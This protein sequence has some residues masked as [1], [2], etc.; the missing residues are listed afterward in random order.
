MV[1]IF[2]KGEIEMNL[3]VIFKRLGRSEFIENNIKRKIDFALERFRED[4]DLNAQVKVE[5]ENA[6]HKTGDETYKCQVNVKS[7]SIPM[8][9]ISKKSS[10]LY[11]AIADAFEK[12]GS[13]VS[14]VRS[15]NH[16]KKRKR[17]HLGNLSVPPREVD[18]A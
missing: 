12:L 1:S 9:F 18:V 6:H 13:V 8:I 14:K 17:I 2:E 3:R 10:N 15:Q 7:K 11:K 4:R 16:T 5:L